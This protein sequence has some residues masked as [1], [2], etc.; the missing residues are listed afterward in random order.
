MNDKPTAQVSRNYKEKIQPFLDTISSMLRNGQPER[1]VI[2]FLGIGEGVWVRSKR[3]FSGLRE[4]VERSRGDADSAVEGALL[5]SACGYTYDEE[6]WEMD[7][8][9]GK[10][11]I[12][13]LTKIVKKQYTPNVAAAIFW[14]CNRKS[15]E[16]KNMQKV[17]AVIDTPRNF[18]EFMKQAAKGE[19][20]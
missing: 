16:W 10:E 1:E 20:K 17:E 5:R 14:L 11:E 18:A 9:K 2:E 3:L 19:E 7:R 15:K 4:T 12:L 13:I 8:R 6:T